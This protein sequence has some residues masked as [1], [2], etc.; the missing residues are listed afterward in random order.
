[1]SRA[2]IRK[3]SAMTICWGIYNV[4]RFKLWKID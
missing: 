2:A 1:V 4:E 3:C